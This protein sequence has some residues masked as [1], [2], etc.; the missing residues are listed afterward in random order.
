M[1]AWVSGRREESCDAPRP[2]PW[3]RCS[4]K[5]WSDRSR[6][7]SVV[8]LPFVRSFVRPIRAGARDVYGDRRRTR[9]ASCGLFDH[10]GEPPVDGLHPDAQRQGAR[11]KEG[12]RHRDRK[13]SENLIAFWFSQFPVGIR[14]RSICLF[15]SHLL[16][17]RNF[18][19]FWVCVIYVDLY[20]ILPYEHGISKKKGCTLHLSATPY[21]AKTAVTRFLKV[22]TG[23]YEGPR[24]I[25]CVFSKLSFGWF[26]TYIILRIL[27]L[28][29]L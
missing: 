1:R 21:F 23:F 17:L 18:S 5:R 19:L 6:L 27:S 16:S 26:L 7:S 25:C 20:N 8:L 13:V 22:T 14:L 9:A 11:E 3:N 12:R 24:W 15:C 28:P 2:R 4:P 10:D 29:R